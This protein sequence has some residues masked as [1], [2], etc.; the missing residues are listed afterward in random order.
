MSHNRILVA[1]AEPD[2]AQT[3]TLALE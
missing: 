3:S 2:S 1:D